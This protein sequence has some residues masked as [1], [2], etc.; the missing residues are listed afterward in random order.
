LKSFL[1]ES[2]TSW[3]KCERSIGFK[4]LIFLLTT[5][6]ERGIFY[7]FYKDLYAVTLEYLD[8]AVKPIAY[9]SEEKIVKGSPF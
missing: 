5:N 8:E 2:N 6:Q 7:A 4:G 9:K 3:Q 1:P